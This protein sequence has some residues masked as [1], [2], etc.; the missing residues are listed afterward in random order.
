M[1]VWVYKGR[2]GELMVFSEENRHLAR[3]EQDEDNNAT[4]EDIRQWAESDIDGDPD[5]GDFS[6]DDGGSIHLVEVK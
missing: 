5:K 6:I 1:N 4:V 3:K 2:H